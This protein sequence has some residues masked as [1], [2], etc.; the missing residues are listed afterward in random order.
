MLAEVASASGIYCGPVAIAAILHAD[1]DIVIE[2]CKEAVFLK[3]GGR[4]PLYIKGMALD[5]IR[6]TIEMLTG[7]DQTHNHWAFFNERDRPLIVREWL[8]SGRSKLMYGRNLIVCG[9]TG[10]TLH[11]MAV[12]KEHAVDT[13]SKGRIVP[14]EHLNMRRCLMDSFLSFEPDL[15]IS[16]EAKELYGRSIDPTCPNKRRLAAR[17]FRQPR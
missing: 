5:H 11:A 13:M 1:I 2:A 8:E 16:E 10:E 6:I 7:V 15:R 9:G 17:S 4:R 14:V 12:H 3:E